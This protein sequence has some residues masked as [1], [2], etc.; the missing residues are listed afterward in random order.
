MNSYANDFTKTVQTYYK[1]L[2]KYNPTY[3]QYRNFSQQTL[4]THQPIKTFTFYGVLKDPFYKID[5]AP[6][7]LGIRE[8][9][10]T[11]VLLVQRDGI[12]LE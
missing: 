12:S 9:A 5:E 6:R 11:A 10:P 4:I 8:D 2:K 3:T 7:V 1:D